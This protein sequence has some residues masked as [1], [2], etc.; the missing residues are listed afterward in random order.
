MEMC[1]CVPRVVAVVVLMV[2]LRHGGGCQALHDTQQPSSHPAGRF[3]KTVPATVSSANIHDENAWTS[4]ISTRISAIKHNY[5]PEYKP[6]QEDNNKNSK[7]VPASDPRLSFQS[8]QS[9]NT[10]NSRINTQISTTEAKDSSSPEYQINQNANDEIR[11]KDAR[12]PEVRDFVDK[13]LDARET[14]PEHTKLSGKNMISHENPPE[15]SDTRDECNEICCIINSIIISAN[16][17][18]S[19]FNDYKEDFAM[20]KFSQSWDEISSFISDNYSIPPAIPPMPE[21]IDV[22]QQMVQVYGQLQQHLLG[23]ENATLDQLDFTRPSEAS[24]MKTTTITSPNFLQ[25]LTDTINNINQLLIYVRN[26][27]DKLDV[28]PEESLT[29]E[30]TREVYQTSDSIRK[31]VIDFIILRNYE[32]G[33]RYIID[34]FTAAHSNN[35][36]STSS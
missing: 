14:E 23:F 28:V 9:D 4:R 8:L 5:L 12:F 10:E 35:C 30:L 16:I 2:L 1:W 31:D 27:M 32:R 34:V 20:A 19:L 13:I 33:L 11:S 26:G 15:M 6:G 18:L 17:H 22:R 21:I 7:A 29:Q 3:N 36:A 24:R 25:N